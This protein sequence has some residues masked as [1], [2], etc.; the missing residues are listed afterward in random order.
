MRKLFSFS[1]LVWAL[2]VLVIL[3]AQTEW[4][5]PGLETGPEWWLMGTTVLANV[6]GYVEGLEWGE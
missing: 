3:V 2:P 6:L 4:I 1:R 5:A